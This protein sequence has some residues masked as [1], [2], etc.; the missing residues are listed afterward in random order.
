MFQ[1]HLRIT[2][3]SFGAIGNCVFDDKFYKQVEATPISL[4]IYNCYITCYMQTFDKIAI[5]N[6]NHLCFV[7]HTIVTWFH[8]ICTLNQ[9]ILQHLNSNKLNIEVE[10]ERIRYFLDVLVIRNSN[11][12]LDHTINRKKTHLNLYFNPSHIIM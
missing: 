6:L 10:E 11:G 3:L 7:D 12:I 9:N 1:F 8:R 2:H 4:V 5:W